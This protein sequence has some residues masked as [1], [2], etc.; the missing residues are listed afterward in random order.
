MI[1]I[2]NLTKEYPFGFTLKIDGLIINDGERVALTGPNGSGK[3]TLLRLLSGI[4]KPDS[5]EARLDFEGG[6]VYMPQNAYSF[7]KSVEENIRIGLSDN[8]NADKK[9][10]QILEKVDLAAFAKKRANRLSGGERQRMLFA[11]MLV[12]SHKCLLLDEPLGAVDIVRV[13][14]LEDLLKDY[15]ERNGTTLII[16]THL[17]QQAVRVSDKIIIMNNGRVEEYGKTVEV[18]QSPQ[19]EFGKLFLEQWRL[20]KC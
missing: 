15:C 16:A 14:A 7:K 1:K 12:E 2:D 9:V 19:T 8:T 11:R 3:T 20:N 10:M 18:I 6:A 13:R 4:T 17:P 5:G